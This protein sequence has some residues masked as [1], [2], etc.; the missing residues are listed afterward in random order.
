MN[1]QIEKVTPEIAVEYLNHNITHNRTIQRARVANLALRMK[2]GE[3]QLNGESI[4]FNSKGELIDG[5]HRLSAVIASNCPIETLVIRECDATIMDDGKMRSVRDV[6]SLSRVDEGLNNNANIAIAKLHYIRKS[7]NGAGVTPEMIKEFL[8]EH[9]DDIRFVHSIATKGSTTNRKATS[10]ASFGL[11]MLYAI[12]ADITRNEAER[13]TEIMQS[14]FYSNP[15]ETA[16]IVLRNDVLGDKLPTHLQP[17]RVKKLYACE[18]AFYDF[19]NGISRKNTYS[20]I[21]TPTYSN[22]RR[23]DV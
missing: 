18:R 20:I 19:H 14:G 1:I 6:F 21:S 3:W 8:I 7:V 16:A 15:S 23:W 5:Q 9:E 12:N 4:K 11:A 13:F 22:D 2:R 10:G 17:D